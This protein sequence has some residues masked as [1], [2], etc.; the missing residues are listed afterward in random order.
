M[1]TAENP[2]STTKGFILPY[3]FFLL[4]SYHGH[5][6]GGQLLNKDERRK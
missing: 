3:Y 4:G 6:R 5:P 2:P 1:P